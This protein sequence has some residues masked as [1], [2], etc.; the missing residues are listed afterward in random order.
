LCGEEAFGETEGIAGQARNDG[1]RSG[2]IAAFAEDFR[3]LE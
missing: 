2:V 3:K 1:D